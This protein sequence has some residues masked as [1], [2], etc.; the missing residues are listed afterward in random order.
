[1]PAALGPMT[2]VG[3]AGGL[4]NE[5]VSLAP[6]GQGLI[7]VQPGGRQDV[8]AA[9]HRHARHP[10]LPVQ[11]GRHV[12]RDEAHQHVLDDV[13]DLDTLAG[14][15]TQ[16]RRG[17]PPRDL[18]GACKVDGARIGQIVRARPA[19]CVVHGI[20]FVVYCVQCAPWV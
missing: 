19:S 1:M 12:G 3:D 9:V 13:L 20:P 17:D 5:C 10:G 4:V 2:R 18:L 8:V 6:F 11:K 14:S 7:A 16:P 15:P